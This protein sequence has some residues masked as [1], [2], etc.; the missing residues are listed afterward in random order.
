MTRKRILASVGLG[1]F[2]AAVFAIIG[3]GL[4]LF[5]RAESAAIAWRLGLFGLFVGSLLGLFLDKQLA[6]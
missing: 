6:D 5:Q 3:L 4:I 1:L 2:T